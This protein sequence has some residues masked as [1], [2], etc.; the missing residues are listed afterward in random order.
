NALK[1][2]FPALWLR[3]HFIHRP[4]SAEIELSFLD[5][6]ISSDAITVDVG[7]NCGLYTRELA[8]LSWR[9]HAF[10]PSHKMADVLRQTSAPNVMV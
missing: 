6:V 2:A 4:K 8:R 3:W 1:E 9:V 10:E 7:A 5:K